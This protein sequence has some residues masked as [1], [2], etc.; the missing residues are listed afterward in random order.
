MKQSFLV[1]GAGEVGLAILNSLYDYQEKHGQ[2]LD[3]A[4]LVQPLASSVARIKNN[5]KFINVTVETADL[6][7]EN[8]TALSGIFKKYDTVICCS[9]FST[10]KGMQVKITKAV[11]DAGVSRYI[12]WQFGVDYDKIG[13]GSAQPSFDEQLDV[14][15]LL[16]AQHNT[17]WII[18]STGMI[19]SFLFREDFGVVS[20]SDK[21]VS[22]LGSW[23]HALTLT[24]CED[25]GRLTIEILFRQP[26]ISDQVV[27]IAGDTLTFK[28]LAN[29]LEKVFNMEFKRKLW[30]IPKLQKAA[31]EDP[32][33]VFNRYRL[34]FTNPGVTWPM[35]QTFNYQHRIPTVDVERWVKENVV[36]Q[37][38]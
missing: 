32:A 26:E 13:R 34:V 8:I 9:G 36:N 33:D 30:D 21:T 29:T 25:I 17:H 22:A 12:P 6:V 18:V 38:A 19:T 16:R 7:N 15:D 14:R 20:L 4:V 27:F 35:T 23:Q 5:P 11:L 2:P 1:I 24:S 31:I 28:E 37:E 3:I 10:G